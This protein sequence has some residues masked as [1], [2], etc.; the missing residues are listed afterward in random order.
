MKD[1]AD[2]ILTNLVSFNNYVD[3]MHITTDVDHSKR[4]K[5]PSK[6]LKLE[7]VGLLTFLNK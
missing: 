4:P 6:S 5:D 3:V 7:C 2:F 1:G